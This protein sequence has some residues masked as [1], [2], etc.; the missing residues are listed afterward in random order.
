MY[1]V[2]GSDGQKYGPVDVSTLK[3][4]CR[5]GRVTPTTN[6]VDEVSGRVVP[7][8][9]L[10]DLFDVFTP[11]PSAAPGP[12]PAPGGNPYATQQPQAGM[13]QG[14]PYAEQW[15]QQG[16]PGGAF[17]NAPQSPYYRNQGQMA[18]GGKTKVA[19]ILLALFLGGLGIHRFYL[20]YTTIGVIQLVCTLTVF[21]SPISWI[22]ALVDLIMIATGSL[23]D[24]QGMDLA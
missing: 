5:E 9:T 3:N 21:L 22:W 8:S 7:A 11:A 13:G 24:A 18:Y 4:W 16:Q 23:K 14:S 12:Q 19:G 15:A 6:I 2:M 1:S 10:Q 17:S 20:G